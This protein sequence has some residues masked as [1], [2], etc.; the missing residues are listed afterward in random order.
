MSYPNKDYHIIENQ[1]L[2]DISLLY[3]NNTKYI[4]DEYIAFIKKLTIFD[5]SVATNNRRD[6]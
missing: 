6:K 1:Q 3:K 2:L 5:R 4:P